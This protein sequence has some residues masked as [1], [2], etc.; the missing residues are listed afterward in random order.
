MHSPGTDILPYLGVTGCLS[1]PKFHPVP[2]W[3]V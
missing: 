3:P 2:V 1:Y